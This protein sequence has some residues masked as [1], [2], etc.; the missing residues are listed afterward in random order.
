MRTDRRLALKMGK[1]I[2]H[3][4]CMKSTK[5]GGIER[6]I[7]ETARKC[8]KCGYNTVVQY[9][10]I[11]VLCPTNNFTG[12]RPICYGPVEVEWDGQAEC[13]LDELLQSERSQL[14]L[15]SCVRAACRIRWCGAH[16]SCCCRPLA[17]PTER[18]PGVAGLVLRWSVCGASV[19]SNAASPGC[20]RNFVR[21]D[22]AAIATNR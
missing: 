14:R 17:P 19:I 22:R 12:V 10:S 2:L 3:L 18:S 6:Y 11:L 8:R 21:A 5:Y 4:T 7:L 15:R 13:S 20:T 16:R 9:P 1:T